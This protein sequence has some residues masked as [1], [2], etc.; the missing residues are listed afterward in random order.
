[1]AFFANFNWT[2]FD[3]DERV[4]TCVVAYQLILVPLVTF[5]CWAALPNLSRRMVW[6]ERINWERCGCERRKPN[7]RDRFLSTL[8]GLGKTLSRST[9]PSRYRSVP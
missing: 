3:L 8:L 1:M 4:R 7:Y 2:F 9:H 5:K 6:S